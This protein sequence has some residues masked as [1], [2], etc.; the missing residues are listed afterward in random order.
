[1]VFWA[2]DDASPLDP[3]AVTVNPSGGHTVQFSIVKAADTRA[4]FE[5]TKLAAAT[6]AEL[7]PLPFI[8]QVAGARPDG[9]PMLTTVLAE[10]LVLG[11][12]TRLEVVFGVRNC[13][14]GP[15]IDFPT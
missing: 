14:E 6:S 2:S 7:G 3:A 13:N 9:T 11:S 8:R 4:P 15:R 10:R 1:M 5:T 12:A